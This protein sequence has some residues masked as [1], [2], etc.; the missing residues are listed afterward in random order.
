MKEKHS[1]KFSRN[2]SPFSE[3][4]HH[5]LDFSRIIFMRRL[6]RFFLSSRL[7]VVVLYVVVV[8]FLMSHDDVNDVY[9]R[10]HIKRLFVRAFQS[11]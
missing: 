11:R 7:Y 6:K 2:F 5:R 4:S 1:K 9:E 10:T 8:S 3:L